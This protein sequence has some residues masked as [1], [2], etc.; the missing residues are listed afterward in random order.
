MN[1]ILNINEFRNI[2]EGLFSWASGLI[3]QGKIKTELDKYYKELPLKMKERLGVE[4][5]IELTK[6]AGGNTDSMEKELE[7]LKQE[8]ENLKDGLT[9]AIDEVVAKRPDLKTKLK[10]L[11]IEAKKTNLPKI[12]TML[13]EFQKNPDFKAVSDIVLTKLNALKTQEKEF[14]TEMANI[15]KAFKGY[16]VGD[17]YNYTTKEGSANLIMLTTVTNDD[18]GTLLDYKAKTVKSGDALVDINKFKSA[19]E[20][21]PEKTRIGEKVNVDESEETKTLYLPYTSTIVKK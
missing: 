8:E 19:P 10:K 15:E 20:I 11:E 13:Q 7:I 4:F 2:N 12:R 3:K 21:K 1:N 17:I 6:K 5:K 14:N 16:Q 18:K 9:T